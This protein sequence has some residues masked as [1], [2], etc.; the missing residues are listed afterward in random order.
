MTLSPD[1]DYSLA[2]RVMKRPSTDTHRS[3]KAW[4][5]YHDF[6][7]RE[8]ADFLKISQSMYSKL[9]RGERFTRGPMAKKISERAHVPVEV[10][11]G[12]I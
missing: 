3:L 6:S 9:E 10:L 2:I 5:E 4:R 7:T 1:R 11:V 8:A 12:A